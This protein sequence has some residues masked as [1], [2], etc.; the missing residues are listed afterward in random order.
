MKNAFA[1][2]SLARRLIKTGEMLESFAMGGQETISD[3]P[4]MADVYHGLFIDEVEHLQ[5][6]TL[7]LTKLVSGDTEDTSNADEGGDGS[8][9][10]EGDLTTGK[11]EAP[12]A[13]ESK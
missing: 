11:G 12:P 3:Y 10:A 2:G 7:E 13:E 6:L 9:F 4:E 5:I 8:V 1:I